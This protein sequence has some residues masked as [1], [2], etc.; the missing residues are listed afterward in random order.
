MVTEGARVSDSAVQGLIS[1]MK[2]RIPELET[3]GSGWVFQRVSTLQIHLAKYKPLKASS[4]FELKATLQG[5]IE[6][7][8]KLRDDLSE[9]MRKIAEDAAP[10]VFSTTNDHC[11]KATGSTG[12]VDTA[13][14]KCLCELRPHDTG[15]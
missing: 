12:R 4:Y 8:D 11:E 7:A 6:K 1:S 14:R 13:L 10:S 15:Q 2:E 3:K 5:K 9:A